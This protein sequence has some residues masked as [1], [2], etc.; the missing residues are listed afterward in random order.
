MGK[1]EKYWYGKLKFYNF[2][3]N[4]FIVLIFVI[5]IMANKSLIYDKGTYPI[6]K[7]INTSIKKKK[8]RKRKTCDF[9]LLQII[10][11]KSVGWMVRIL[12][13]LRA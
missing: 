4:L 6:P 8:K 2:Y 3:H 12:V 1:F 10:L 13:I 11:E 7:A 9:K 5:S